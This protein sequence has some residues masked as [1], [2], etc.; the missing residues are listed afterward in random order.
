MSPWGEE[1]KGKVKRCGKVNQKEKILS[2][3]PGFEY[4]PSIRLKSVRKRVT[5][6]KGGRKKGG[7]SS[8]RLTRT[9]EKKQKPDEAHVYVEC[10]VKKSCAEGEAG[11]NR[12]S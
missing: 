5:P 2:G 3:G 8:A 9:R 10:R 1:S 4:V 6:A 11:R 7:V 12:G